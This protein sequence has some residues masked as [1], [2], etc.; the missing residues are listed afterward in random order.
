MAEKIILRMCLALKTENG[1]VKYVLPFSG[2]CSTDP[3]RGSANQGRAWMSNCNLTEHRLR[4]W[5]T[6]PCFRQV[7]GA[8]AVHP[9]N[10]PLA[11]AV[12]FCTPVTPSPQTYS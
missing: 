10:E 8:A 9:Q 3:Q 2:M 12:L 1:E 5:L 6:K 4:F 7:W 11:G